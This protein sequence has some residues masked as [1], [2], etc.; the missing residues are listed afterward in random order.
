MM[1]GM[2]MQPVRASLQPGNLDPQDMPVRTRLTPAEQKNADVAAARESLEG[3]QHERLL[4]GAQRWVSQTFFGTLLKQM[5]ES[6]F[7]SEL[8][9]GGRGGDAFA[10]LYDQHLADRMARASGRPLAA[11]IVKHI[12][13]A[14]AR[15]TTVQ[16]KAAGQGGIAKSDQGIR[17]LSRSGV[18]H[19]VP[20][21]R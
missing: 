2:M 14:R 11:S 16:A 10:G 4:K 8:F 17:S 18:M 20:P 15:G 3:G 5:R 12:E 13:K 1:S 6:P 19:H 9:S 21:T 7:K